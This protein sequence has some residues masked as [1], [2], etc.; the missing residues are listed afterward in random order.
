MSEVLHTLELD[1]AP[2]KGLV[3]ITPVRGAQAIG[4]YEEQS[5]AREC[6]GYVWK[7]K[8]QREKRERIEG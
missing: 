6:S 3:Q 7:R 4:S 8:S 2:H 5:G 1:L